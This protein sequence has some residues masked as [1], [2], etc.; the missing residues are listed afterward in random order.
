MVKNSWGTQRGEG[1][2]FRIQ[3]GDRILDEFGTPV[4]SSSQPVS[5]TNIGSIACAPET[6]SNPSQDMMVMSAADV[7]VMQLNGRIPCRDNSTATSISLASIASATSQ[8]VD[9]VIFTFNIVVNV[10]GCTQTTQ[11][12]IDAVVDFNLDGT[13]AL[14]DHTYRYVDNQVGCGAA[15][16]SSTILLV[17]VAIVMVV[18][19]FAC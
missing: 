19:T 14:T 10:Q 15:T 11:A 1:G 2:Y 16:I 6:V 8:I 3:R 4:L 18:P 17:I 5:S 13:F 12:C 7:A 9:G